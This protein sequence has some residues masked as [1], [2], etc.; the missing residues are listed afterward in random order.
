MSCYGCLCRTCARSVELD[1]RYFTPGELP[2]GV[3]PCFSC[4]ECRY[5]DGDWR[6]GYQKRAECSGYVEA[7]KHAEAA[8]A[9]MRRKMKIIK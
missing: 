2:P 8:A 3:E 6:K 5:Y 7:R 1:L 4:D 9:A